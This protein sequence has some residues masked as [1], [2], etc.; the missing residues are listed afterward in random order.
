MTLEFKATDS[1]TRRYPAVA[2]AAV[3]LSVVGLGC[4]QGPDTGDVNP[5]CETR[6]DC[7]AGWSCVDSVCLDLDDSVM[8]TETVAPGDTETQACGFCGALSRSCGA[9]GEFGEW[10]GCRDE[11]PCV[12]GLVRVEA[13]DDRDSQRVSACGAD[14]QWAD[15]SECMAPQLEPVVLEGRPPEVAEVGR[16]YEF[17]PTATSNNLSWELIEGPPGMVVDELGRVTWTADEAGLG[18][19]EVRLRAVQEGTGRSGEMAWRVTAIRFVELSTMEVPEDRSVRLLAFDPGPSGTVVVEIAEAAFGPN[20]TVEVQRVIGSTPPGGA[21]VT[22][23][24]T[25]RF[26]PAAQALPRPAFICLP[27]TPRPSAEGHPT[28]FTRPDWLEDWTPVTTTHAYLN[29]GLICGRVETLGIVAAGIVADLAAPR[30][31]DAVALRLSLESESRLMAQLG[32][33][34]QAI[35]LG[36]LVARVGPSDVRLEQR[37]NIWRQGGPEQVVSLLGSSV[38]SFD[39]QFDRDQRGGHCRLVIGS[40]ESRSLE[41]IGATEGR[42]PGVGG[43]T[44]ADCGHGG[45]TDL[46]SGAVLLHDLSAAL[47]SESGWFIEAVVTVSEGRGSRPVSVHRGRAGQASLPAETTADWDADQDAI[48]DACAGERGS[49]L[50]RAPGC[51]GGRALPAVTGPSGCLLV[52]IC[53]N[54]LDDDCDA[55]IDEQCDELGRVPERVALRVVAI[56]A[57]GGRNLVD[58]RE[59]S[60]RLLDQ[61]EVSLAHGDAQLDR[62]SE[63]RWRVPEGL[64]EIEAPAPATYNRR[65][66][67]ATP[68][69]F[70]VGVVASFEGE[71]A[72]VHAPSVTLSVGACSDADGDSFGLGPGCVGPDCHDGDPTINPAASERCDGVDNNCDGAHDD[73]CPCEPVHSEQPCNRNLG[74]CREGVQTC[75]PLG[76]G[77]CV[78]GVDPDAETCDGLD[79]DCDGE[80]DELPPLVCGVGSC[81]RADPACLEGVA[82]ECRALVGEGP[83]IC[84]GIDNDCNGLIDEKAFGEALT[85]ACYE[86]PPATRGVGRCQDGIRSCIQGQYGD[87]AGQRLPAVEAC[88][89]DR[90]DED[91]DGEINEAA[92]VGGE[93]CVCVEG[94]SRPC[95]GPEVGACSFGQQVCRDNAWDPCAGGRAP[96]AEVCDAAAADE[97]CD[98]QANEDCD[99][100]EGQ[101]EACGDDVGACVSGVRRCNI[102]GQ[103]GACVGAVPPLAREFCDGQGIDEDCDGQVNEDCGCIDGDETPCGSDVGECSLGVRRCSIHGIYGSCVG[104]GS[105]SPEGCDGLDNDCDNDVDEGLEGEPLVRGCY[106]GL[107]ATRRVGE[108]QDGRQVC[109]EGG[110]TGCEGQTLPGLEECD[111]LDNDCDG[112]TD[113]GCP[114]SS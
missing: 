75:T 100:D 98:G 85:R 40:E 14:C 73:G 61:I 103:W 11:G 110:W 108:C 8:C 97:D 10:S 88:D 32:L 6:L 59:H 52:E 2:W 92:E 72:Y 78:G 38:V 102:D 74:V 47:A 23:G 35:P 71:E 34:E 48:T 24:P 96:G 15:A 37:I 49:P 31:D 39:R 63:V 69:E 105:P 60:F 111:E 80:V 68:G 83:E 107:V 109:D 101:E 70:D 89:V 28:L 113:E 33:P 104:A 87:C 26:A 41:A 30:G 45:L 17:L 4:G 58:P 77:G 106:D 82:Q 57:D 29:K 42:W 9:S 16:Y 112:Q 79:N 19:A 66:R 7:S 5:P 51:A 50:L 65:F 36:R 13:C 21:G 27:W 12:P 86:G 81:E 20:T 94:E 53:G 62:P 114:Q 18:W 93:P 1:V 3:L 22:L 76:W 54:E 64:V 84:D 44:W 95:R 25:Y 90:V 91:C 56:A 55:I 67:V 99:C 46:L 43:D